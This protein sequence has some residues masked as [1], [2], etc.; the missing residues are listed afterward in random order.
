MFRLLG[1]YVWERKWL[2]AVIVV[3]LVVY[4][5]TLL[6]PTQIIQGLVDKLGS[7][8]LTQAGLWTDLALL[9]G[10]ASLNYLSA[11]L[12]YY[13]LFGASTGFKFSLQQAAFRKLLAM[14]TAFYDRFR[15]G[16]ILTRFTTDVDGLE[17]LLGYGLMVVV[18]AGGMVAFILPAMMLLSWW[19][20]FLALI[21]LLV[22]TGVIYVVAGRQEALIDRN[23]DAVA[24]LNNEVL[25]VVEGV[26]VTRAYS[27]KAVQGQAFAQGTKDL[28]QIGDQMMAYQ[29][30][31]Q[32][33]STA[34]IGLSTALIL[35]LGGQEMA[36]GSMSLGQVLA[37][38]L[39]MLSLIEP[40]W[41]FSDII[42]VYQT[43]KTSFEKLQELLDAGDDMEADGFLTVSSP[44]SYA[45][46]D[47]SFTYPNADR[48]SLTGINWTL[49]KGQ[50]VGIVGKTGS[51]KTTLI[52][53]FLRQY[54][55][56]QGSLTIDGQ[57][58]TGYARKSLEAL[59]GY[60]P[61]EHI[62][63]SRSVRENILLGQPA[64]SPADLER[65]LE[66][67]AFS[68]D[69]AMMSQ[70]L[71]TLIGEKGV[72]I[73]GG[74]K[75]RLSIARAFLRQ[76]EL[77]ILDDSL[78]AVDAKTE[79]AIISHIQAERAGQTTLIVAHRLSAV[80]HA[81]WVLVMDE[82]RIVQEGRPDD[83]LAQGGWYAD[84]YYRQQGEEGVAHENY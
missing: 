21:P 3:A 2:Y 23:R 14:R 4:D 45:F 17:T 22:M 41:M 76:P 52:R 54:P 75:Q 34:M 44:T 35:W 20:S 7:Q 74:Q 19:I 60:V 31:Y 84:Q 25:E 53:Q 55:L 58:I 5:L 59:L 40:L 83:L 38:Q 72:S 13:K 61:Q 50:T 1:R 49:K 39:Y 56:G 57:S 77:L 8:N 9:L 33:L 28:R 32:P 30:I 73:S 27:K 15:S 65:A 81:D 46:K 10:A 37:L 71:D 78:S 82:G 51:G 16:D 63:F 79:Q 69:V 6:V 64:A 70:G 36:T 42:L 12:W 62:L 67:A 24:A 68:Q 80:H 43:G 48:P 66:T 47:Y 11:Y 29:A 26:R 18:Y